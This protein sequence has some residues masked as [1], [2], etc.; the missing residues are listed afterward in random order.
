VDTDGSGFID[1]SEFVLATSDRKALLSKENLEKT[2]AHFD[3]D[4]SGTISTAELKKMLGDFGVEE[5]VWQKII[6]EVDSDKNGEIDLKEFK[7]M[8]IRMV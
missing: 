2:F 5:D 4:G 6:D 1:Y 7:D 3:K 8:M